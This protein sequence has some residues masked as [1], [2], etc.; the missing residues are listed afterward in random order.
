MAL[1]KFKLDLTG[2][3]ASGINAFDAGSSDVSIIGGG[4]TV[5]AA[6]KSVG[7]AKLEGGAYYKGIHNIDASKSADI[8]WFGSNDGYDTVSNFGTKEGDSVF[9]YDATSIDAVQI[10]AEGGSAKVVFKDTSCTLTLTGISNIDDV[11]FMLN[12][13]DGGYAYYKYDSKTS[14]FVQQKA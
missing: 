14:A 7:S 10:T 13:A 3:N 5:K 4:A 9:L 12:A 1:E 6:T 8:F 2:V 11:K